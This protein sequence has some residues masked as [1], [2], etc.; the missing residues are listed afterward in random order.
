MTYSEETKIN[1][2]FRSDQPSYAKMQVIATDQGQLFDFDDVILRNL[3]V[4]IYSMGLI[5]GY[6][7]FKSLITDTPLLFRP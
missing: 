2:R 4:S 7:Q 1:A 6:G 3:L 5:W